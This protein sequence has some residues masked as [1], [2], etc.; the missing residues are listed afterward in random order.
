MGKGSGRDPKELSWPTDFLCRFRPFG[1]WPSA[2]C[3]TATE[4]FCPVTK[5]IRGEQVRR[6]VLG[7]EHVDRADAQKTPFDERF[8]QYI[9][10]SAWGSVWSDYGLDRRTRSLLTNVLLA[11][12]SHWE[13]MAMHVRASRRTGVTAEELREA[14]M[15]VAVY[16]GVPA[17][18]RAFAIAKAIL[19]ESE[20]EGQQRE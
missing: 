20:G 4:R 3:Q 1:P 16:A 9:T 7:D 14:L 15:H 2:G 8:Q 5:R 11:A 13:E 10:E 12:Q 18:N 17:A 19:E 6:E